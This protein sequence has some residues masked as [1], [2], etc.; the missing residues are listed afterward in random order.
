MNPARNACRRRPCPA[1]KRNAFSLVEVVIAMAVF[2]FS[3]PIL[4]AVMPVGLDANRFSQQKTAAVDLCSSI[5]SDLRGT[6][7]AAIASPLYGIPVPPAPSATVPVPETT[8]CVLYDVYN[9]GTSTFSPPSPP[10]VPTGS[11]YRFTIT[12]TPAVATSPNDPAIANIVVT[13]PAQVDPS[14]RTMTNKVSVC[15][16]ISRIKP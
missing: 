9:G 14:T 1:G 2:V 12:I 5:E 4:V 13:W 3:I 6:S 16:A 15:V 7:A 11:Q 10:S 8:T